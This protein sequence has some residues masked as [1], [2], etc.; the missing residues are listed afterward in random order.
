MCGAEHPDPLTR[1]AANRCRYWPPRRN[2]GGDP[3]DPGATSMPS[4]RRPGGENTAADRNPHDWRLKLPTF[5]NRRIVPAGAGHPSPAPAR[6][7]FFNPPHRF[8]IPRDEPCAR[9]R[10]GAA[11]TSFA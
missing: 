7:F 11:L 4:P 1:L 3:A 2:V 10:F 9:C 6:D 5:R 8:A